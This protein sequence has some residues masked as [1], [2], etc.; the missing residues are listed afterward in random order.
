[1]IELAAERGAVR[2]VINSGPDMTGAHQLYY[3]MGF[4]RLIERETRIVDGHTRPLLA[5]GY[6]VADGAGL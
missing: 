6:E 5:F 4:T 2:F 3:S 1:M